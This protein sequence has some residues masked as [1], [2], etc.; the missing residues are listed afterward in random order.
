MIYV[1]ATRNDHPIG[2]FNTLGAA[3]K[4]INDHDDMFR[5]AELAT[6]ERLCKFSKKQLQAHFDKD[7]DVPIFD[8]DYILFYTLLEVKQMEES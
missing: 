6:H 1:L 8:A 3:M 7:E 2:Y 5:L 4:Y